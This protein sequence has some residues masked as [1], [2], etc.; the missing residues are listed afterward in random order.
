MKAVSFDEQTKVLNRPDSMTDEECFSL[1]VWCGD[2]QCISLWKGRFWERIK[3][4]FTGEM[5]FSS[6]SGQT[7][8]PVWLSVDYPFQKK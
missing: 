4:L 6:Y 5:W 3:F 1:P 8:P 7:Q 2:G